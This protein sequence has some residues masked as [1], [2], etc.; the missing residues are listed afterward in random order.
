MSRILVVEDDEVL[1]NEL[2][3]L[4]RNEGYEA[5]YI[6]TFSDT[7]GQIIKSKP[8]LVLLDINIPELNGELVL[9]KLRKE[10]DIPVIM[11]TSRTSESDE[12]LSMSYGAD[13]Y[14]TKP[15]NPTILMLRISAVIKRTRKQDS[16]EAD[17]GEKGI[18]QYRQ[19]AVNTAK[20]TLS[21]GEKELVLTKNEMIIFLSLLN[22]IGKIVSRDELMTALWD[23]EEYINDNALTV[24]ISRLRA[25]LSDFGYEDAIETRKKQGYC[26]LSCM[27]LKEYIKDELFKII[28]IIVYIILIC[29]LLCAFN[30]G[31]QMAALMAVLAA[32]FFIIMFIWDFCR[33]RNFYNSLID[34]TQRIDKKYLVIE[35]LD[36][37]EFYEGNL[38]YTAMYDINKSMIEH[39]NQY[40]RGQQDFK[41]FI[42]MWVHEIKLPIASLTL[43]CHNDKEHIDKKFITQLNRLDDYADKVLYYVRSENAEKDYSFGKV[44][45]KTII[46]KTAVKNK[47]I[48]LSNNISLNVHDIDTYVNTDAKWLEFI[49]NQIISNSIKYKKTSGE[50]YIE[51]Y[52]EQRQDSGTDKVGY[53]VLHIK[54]NGIGIPAKD[55]D[56]VFIKSYTGSNGR[57]NAKSTGMGLYIAKN[58]CGKLGHNIEIKSIEG[59]YTE[60]EI[61]FYGDS[62]YNPV[63]IE[64]SDIIKN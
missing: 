64:K 60:V 58:M 43:M 56:K 47:D 18:Y 10:A 4:L 59:E 30:F 24:N 33:K 7:A 45:L 37:P 31:V 2:I 12:V 13:D 54:D 49:V 61:T 44:N 20:G 38:V 32:I 1:R 40:E 52:S 28:L 51:V 27:K 50:A 48:I 29:G 8:D 42:E 25:K 46:N 63:N 55:I 15:Y 57:N 6:S 34:N 9:R 62:Y 17:T 35:T 3:E 22:N 16:S 36:E 5:E 14:I 11:V 53:A 41:D 23:N 21:R 19:A 39:I 26:L